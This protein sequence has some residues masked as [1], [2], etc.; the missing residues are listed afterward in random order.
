M[1]GYYRSTSMKQPIGA[2]IG[3]ARMSLTLRCGAHANPL[4]GNGWH[5]AQPYKL[6]A[7]KYIGQLLSVGM[8]LRDLLADCWPWQISSTPLIILQRGVG[9]CQSSARVVPQFS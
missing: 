1:L 3:M 4:V 6:F 9:R 2:S 5:M 8:G 7:S